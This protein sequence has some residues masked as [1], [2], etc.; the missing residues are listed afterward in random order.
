M[1]TPVTPLSKRALAAWLK[2]APTAARNWCQ[3]TGFTAEPGQVALLPDEK[4]NLSGVAVG[5]EDETTLWSLGHLSTALPAGDY[6][7]AGKLKRTK[8]NPSPSAGA[9][10]AIAS[11]ATRKTPR[12]S[13]P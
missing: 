7:L 10:R 8:K 12:S 6:R 3:S 5:V 2:S 1:S 9:S 13:P 11:P 4:G